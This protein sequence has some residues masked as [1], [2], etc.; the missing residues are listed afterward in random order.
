MSPPSSSGGSTSASSAGPREASR[1]DK[2]KFSQIV[3]H[4]D[5]DQL[6]DMVA[7]I[8]KSCPDAITEEDDE[9]VLEVEINSL[10]A[11]T[12]T[13]LLN[14]ANNCIAEG[15]KKKKTKLERT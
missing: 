9:K 7:V 6:G 3:N 11:H 5:S 15:N 8:Q 4:L 10:D 14:F 13:T 1:S 12:L 2:M